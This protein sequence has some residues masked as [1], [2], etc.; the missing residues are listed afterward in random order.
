MATHLTFSVRLVW[1]QAVLWELIPCNLVDRQQRFGT[2]YC[3]YLQATNNCGTW[4]KMIILNISVDIMLEV[5]IDT[6]HW[7]D[8][9]IQKLDVYYVWYLVTQFL[10]SNMEMLTRIRSLFSFLSLSLHTYAFN[11]IYINLFSHSPLQSLIF[12]KV[13][14]PWVSTQPLTEIIIRKLPGK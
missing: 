12:R 13:L 3:L 14:F 4:R 7:T 1:R 2:T 8:V 10:S 6:P 9:F 11:Y 5:W